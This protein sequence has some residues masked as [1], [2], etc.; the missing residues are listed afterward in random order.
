MIISSLKR[1]QNLPSFSVV[2]TRLN[3]TMNGMKV[4]L[5]TGST[6]SIALLL[7]VDF[8]T[9]KCHSSKQSS[10]IG[11]KALYTKCSQ[12]TKNNTTIHALREHWKRAVRGKPWLWQPL[13]QEQLLRLWQHFLRKFHVLL[14][15]SQYHFLFLYTYQ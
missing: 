5:Q 14:S 10:S 9:Q 1:L 6:I 7:P 11:S 4:T 3:D 13:R 12:L 8:L 2:F 15:S